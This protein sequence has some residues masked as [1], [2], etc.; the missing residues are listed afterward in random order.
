MRWEENLENLES[1]VEKKEE[2]EKERPQAIETK[3]DL[4]EQIYGSIDTYNTLISLKELGENID[5]AIKIADNKIK[6]LI[7]LGI[8]KFNL[9]NEE[10]NNIVPAKNTNEN[11]RKNHP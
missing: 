7:N 4:Y 8:K 11:Y 10:I 3:E 2:K 1:T 9:T 5:D 6:E